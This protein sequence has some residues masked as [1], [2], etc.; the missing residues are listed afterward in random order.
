MHATDKRFGRCASYSSRSQYLEYL[1]SVILCCRSNFNYNAIELFW[2]FITLRVYFIFFGLQIK[3][4]T[5]RC[6]KAAIKYHYQ[7][8]LYGLYSTYVLQNITGNAFCKLVY[9]CFYRTEETEETND[10]ILSTI[11]AIVVTVLVLV[12]STLVVFITLRLKISKKGIS[13]LSI[14]QDIL[15]GIQTV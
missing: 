14:N 10:C 8:D 4:V 9:N 11:T 7:I 12:I 1:L 6:R 15:I 13:K 3:S 5:C 2:N